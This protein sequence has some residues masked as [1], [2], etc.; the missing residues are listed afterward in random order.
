[1]SHIQIHTRSAEWAARVASIVGAVLISG[2]FNAG[3]SVKQAM[4]SGAPGLVP[5]V[6]SVAPVA[7]AHQKGA[8]FDL[9]KPGVRSNVATFQTELRDFFDGALLRS[10]KYVPTM[11]DMLIHE[12]LPAELA[13]LPLIESGYRPHAVSPA[14]A[15]GPW[16]FIPETGKRYGLRI[17]SMV[18]ERRD[19]IKSTEAAVQYLK[20]LHEMFGDWELSLAAYNSGEY[21]VARIIA[22]TGAPDFWAMR[23]RGY[24]PSE[25]SQ[26][27]PR[28]LAA[29]RI[30]KA[31]Q[32]Y[33]FVAP[34]G[35]PPFHFE[36]VNVDRQL[37]LATAG[38]LCGVSAS[39]LAELNPALR[40]GITP[41]GYALRVPTGAAEPLRTALASYVEPARPVQRVARAG[42]S[43]RRGTTFAKIDRRRQ[44]AT[45]TDAARSRT[46]RRC[47][48]PARQRTVLRQATRSTAASRAR[49]RE[50]EPSVRVARAGS[51]AAKAPKA[52]ARGR[53]RSG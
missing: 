47:T 17:D 44:V 8:S 35:L 31:P 26:Y 12:G 43:E 38:G 39:E 24:L 6:A 46:A 28:F 22:N 25:T 40:R 5:A 4:T 51:T 3:P 33:G 41:S 42:R 18:D 48:S 29:V 13:Y 7:A 9:D 14:G 1:M 15:V 34:A 53:R 23:E 32:E 30:A 27:V 20:D 19:P 2:C 52:P 45:R 50:A 37:S 36:T 49:R 16:Q 11:T 21:R 10:A